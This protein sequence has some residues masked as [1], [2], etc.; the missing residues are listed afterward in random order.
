MLKKLKA[1][2]LKKLNLREDFE[3]V[4]LMGVMD[5]NKSLV[6]QNERLIKHAT[7]L[8]TECGELRGEVFKLENKKV[9]Q[10]QV[11]QWCLDTLG[12]RFIDFSNVNADGQPPHY[13]D[14]LSPEARKE[15]IAG[16]NSIYTDPKF[17]KVVAYTINLIGNHAIQKAEDDNMKNGKIGII[18][19]RT[20]MTEFMQSHDEF[21]DS[22]KPDEEF[23]PL[24]TM[25]E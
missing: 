3:F 18:G 7:K 22:K 1:K 11:M 10:E 20:L 13:L 6:E 23:D 2:L 19:I 21:V 9:T 8:E 12:V 17:Q 15:W 5:M 14:D 25:P 24:A 4:K 16:L